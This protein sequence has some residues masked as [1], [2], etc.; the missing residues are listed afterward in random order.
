MGIKEQHPELYEKAIELWKTKGWGKRRIAKFLNIPV[1]TV[2]S[3]L[4]KAKDPERYKALK[5]AWFHR[6]KITHIEQL[7]EKWR[8]YRTSEG[9]WHHIKKFL[10]DKLGDTCIL[11]GR[12]GKIHYHYIHNS[13]HSK[14]PSFY[15]EHISEFVPLCPSCHIM[16]GKMHFLFGFTWAEIMELKRV[17][18]R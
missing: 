4:Y 5:R 13:K 6:Y 17:R 14:K 18:G 7:R 8:K 10:Q 3:W 16:V 12:K 15:K 1:S 11:C 9:G 2:G